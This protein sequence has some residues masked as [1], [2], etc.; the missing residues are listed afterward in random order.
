MI[1]AIRAVVFVLIGSFSKV[2]LSQQ[3]IGMQNILNIQGFASGTY[4]S[5]VSLYDWN[6][7]GFDDI[8]L[9]G[10]GVPPKFYLNTGG[11]FQE[12]FFNGIQVSNEVKSVTWVDMDNNGLPDLAFNSFNGGLKL[13]KNNGDFTFTDFTPFAGVV[14]SSTDWGYGVSWADYDNDGYLDLFV[15]NYNFDWAQPGPNHLYHNNG[16]LTFTDVTAQVGID[17]TQAA[18]FMGVWFDYNNDNLVDLL[19]L[20]DRV[21]FQNFLYKNLGNGQFTDV[22][23]ESGSNIFMDSMTGSVG[24]YNNDGWLDYYVTNTPG[25][26]NKL[27]R[28]YSNGSFIDVAADLNL[29]LFQWCW[30]ATWVD[31]NND[32]FQ[33]LFVVTQPF[34]GN[35]SMGNHYL[36]KNTGS[37]FDWQVSAGFAGS[38]GA[39]FATARGDFNNDGH[40][41][42]ITHSFA[43]LGVEV[44]YNQLQTGN[45]LKIALEGV[46]SNRDAVGAK[47]TI[48][49][50]ATRQVRYTM[51]GEQ[52]IS[53]NSQWQ[54]FGLG[55]LSNI[56]SL[57][58]QWPSGHRDK[59]LN[60]SPNQSL[61]IKEGASLSNQIA[62][63]S[64]ITQL[65]PG[66][67]IVLDGG[68]WAS[69]TWSTGQ[70]GRYISITESES[71]SVTVTNAL[72]VPVVSD[73]LV[74]DA[75]AFPN[76]STSVMEPSCYGFNNGSIELIADSTQAITSIT[77]NTNQHE[78]FISDLQ[79]G[80][81]SFTL[82][83]G[84]GCSLN[85]TV[86]LTN[87]PPIQLS[88][89]IS[90]IVAEEN[91]VCPHTY[92]LAASA[93]GGSGD[94]TFSWE[95]FMGTSTTPFLIETGDTVECIPA[96][97]FRVV[98]KVQDVNTCIDSSVVQLDVVL[99]ANA[100][101]ND[102][103]LYPNPFSESLH[104]K[105]SHP[106]KRITLLDLHGK[107]LLSSVNS[108][109]STIR[110][111][112]TE[113]LSAGLYLLRIEAESAV[114]YRKV[115]KK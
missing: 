39:T 67:S 78:N 34:N 56:D 36:M 44:W 66:D 89:I 105:S 46:V 106:I 47:I 87:P 82:N 55:S 74:I 57:I 51:F 99:G 7:D 108:D 28:N 25:N 10:S 41:D 33:D 54:H 1:K 29:R 107:E 43:P 24:D 95:F 109:D 5:G 102:F 12:V 3:F 45:Y 72:G 40:P 92:T 84:F 20:N 53:Q 59:F 50:G 80:M 16:D 112:N 79:A 14:E 42:L 90:E 103:F 62:I 65:C 31:Y 115:Q 83:Y 58:V 48:H 11:Q 73:T 21:L 22:S 60:V 9:L 15:A 23:Q 8:T 91:S 104:L 37:S 85:D 32:T 86:E 6:K 4:G 69:H 70:T 26:G 110:H 18:T 2:G 114:F 17:T 76:Y 13:Y 98:C 88:G 19:V 30:G 101:E 68:N 38:N 81:Y 77:W 75:S 64:G 52:F 111:M 63:L 35:G 94:Y 113:I 100:P 27:F 71:V 96:N 97:G 61:R 93:S 49:T